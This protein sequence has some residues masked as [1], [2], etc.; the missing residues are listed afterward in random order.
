[1][2]T[3]IIGI[4]FIVH[5]LTISLTFLLNDMVFYLILAGKGKNEGQKEGK[6]GSSTGSGS[7]GC[8]RFRQHA[9][10]RK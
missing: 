8:V 3:N 6:V 5:V 1:M 7:R 10:V 2:H 9:V 4:F